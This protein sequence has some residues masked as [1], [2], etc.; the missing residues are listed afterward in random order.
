MT[1]AFFPEALF[2]FNSE[3]VT[4]FEMLG[5]TKSILSSY[6]CKILN[7]GLFAKTSAAM[8]SLNRIACLTVGFVD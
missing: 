1:A 3:V 2:F 4:I 7:S 6:N 8:L 5:E